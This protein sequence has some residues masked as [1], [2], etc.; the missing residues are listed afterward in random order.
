MCVLAN[1]GFCFLTPVSGSYSFPLNTFATLRVVASEV[2]LLTRVLFSFIDIYF[3]TS[4]VYTYE[5]CLT[6]FGLG[7]GGG[8]AF[9]ARANFE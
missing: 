2:F 4:R 5:L 3:T 9:D 7:G 1:V 8:G 6:L